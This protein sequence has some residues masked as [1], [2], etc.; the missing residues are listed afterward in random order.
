M[1]EKDYKVVGNHTVLGNAPGVVFTADLAPHLENFYVTAGHLA[2][3]KEAKAEPL[4]C[5]AC[6]AHGTKAQGAVKYGSLLDLQE[7]YAKDHIGLAA[8]VEEE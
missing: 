4:R 2:V 8:P 3:D 5:P 6:K 1:A 7:H